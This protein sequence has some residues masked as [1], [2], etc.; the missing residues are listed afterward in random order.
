MKRN[1][2]DEYSI[3]VHVFLHI[4]IMSNTLYCMLHF[5]CSKTFTPIHHINFD[6]Y[7]VT[8]IAG[9]FSNT[10]PP[11]LPPNTL[12]PGGCPTFW[13]R[14]QNAEQLST[15]YPAYKLCNPHILLTKRCFR[16]NMLDVHHHRIM[17]FSVISNLPI[18]YFIIF[19]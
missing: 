19:Y 14:F 12:N 13:F 10:F 11:Q 16:R 8:A 6:H 5:L 7:R 9:K 2:T 1:Y 15:R 4:C 17:P 3:S 18:N